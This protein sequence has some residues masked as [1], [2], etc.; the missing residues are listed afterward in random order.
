MIKH[1]FNVHHGNVPC[2]PPPPKSILNAPW[3]RTLPHPST[4]MPW[5]PYFF[6]LV[7]CECDPP[8]LTHQG[9]VLYPFSPFLHWFNGDITPLSG[10]PIAGDLHGIP[11]PRPPL[12]AC[13]GHQEHV[14]LLEA[15]QPGTIGL[16]GEGCPVGTRGEEEGEGEGR[17]EGESR[18]VSLL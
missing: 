2:H 3:Q 8:S 12:G 6:A 9:N 11:V 17:G 15:Q 18:C 14:P 7:Q 4:C 1:S 5:Y 10:M 16:G 13:V